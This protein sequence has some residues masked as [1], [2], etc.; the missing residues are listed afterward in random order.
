M[1]EV[2]VKELSPSPL[3][4]KKMMLGVEKNPKGSVKEVVASVRSSACRYV[5]IRAEKRGRSWSISA[6]S[7]RNFDRDETC[8]RKANSGAGAARMVA[9]EERVL[10]QTAGTAAKALKRLAEASAMLRDCMSGKWG[11][12]IAGHLS[13]N[14]VE[15]FK[16]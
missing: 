6:W 11:T 10:W 7:M 1:R 5:Q 2:V 3:R 4:L 14:G 13:R 15:G 9:L 8:V 16:E 12:K